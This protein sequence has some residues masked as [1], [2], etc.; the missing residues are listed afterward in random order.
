LCREL[1]LMA[2][3]EIK[4]AAAFDA[5]TGEVVARSVVELWSGAPLPLVSS[6]SEEALAAA[7]HA[8]PALPLGCL[9]VSPPADWR[10]RLDALAAFSVHCAAGKLDDAVLAA[11][12]A[13][14]IPVLCYTVNDRQTA[15]SLLERGV[16]SVFSDRIDVLTGL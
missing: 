7:R 14:E 10:R 3:V 15:Q 2:N 13:G 16:A 11:A 12:H 5:I 8:V 9:W 1:G 6:F 4:P